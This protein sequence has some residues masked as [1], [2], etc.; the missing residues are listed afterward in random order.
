[1]HF[2]RKQPNEEIVVSTEERL[3][4]DVVKAEERF[5]ELM[6]ES[7][8]IDQRV[9]NAASGGRW[10]DLRDAQARRGELPFARHRAALLTVDLELELVH[11]R[12]RLAEEE[13]ER[14]G[15]RYFELDAKLFALT[16]AENREYQRASHV[17]GLVH[18]QIKRLR[19]RKETL[20]ARR[21][22]ALDA[23]QVS[24]GPGEVAQD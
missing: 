15:P 6:I 8:G 22:A 19:E 10:N 18:E 12:T 11:E 17:V 20:L 14:I 21:G 16:R 23:L 5:E 3:E 4:A 7:A 13:L 9:R 1:M 24:T 2:L